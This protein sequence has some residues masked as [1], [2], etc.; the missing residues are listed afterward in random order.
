MCGLNIVFGKREDR[1]NAHA[2]MIDRMGHRGIRSSYWED[3]TV[4]VSHR[5]LPIQGLSEADDQ[6]IRVGDHL[7]WGVGELFNFRSF[8]PG[9]SND[10]RVLLNMWLSKGHEAFA[11]F[12]GFWA[13][14][15]YDL[16]HK[17]GYVYVD[18]LA[19]KPLYAM[20]YNNCVHICSEIF[21]LV[22][23]N[24]EATINRSFYSNVIKWGY[25]THHMTPWEQIRKLPAGMVTS[26]NMLGDF[27]ASDFYNP[28]QFRLG[29]E[30]FINDEIFRTLMR[31][32]VKNRLVS[33]L[34][35]G[36][37][38][39]GGLDS[40][41]ILRLVQEETNDYKVF[42]VDNGA[43]RHYIDL[44]GVPSDKLVKLTLPEE[45][46]EDYGMAIYAHEVPI[47]LGSVLPQYLLAKEIQKHGYHVVLSGDGADE[48]FGGYRRSQTYDSQLSDIL[49]LV[50]YHLPRLDRLM[51]AGTI[52]LRCPFLSWP[53]LN[54]AIEIPYHFR[55][56]KEYLKL[57]FK[58]LI[59]KEILDREKEPLKINAIR[60]NPQQARK[61]TIISYLDE[62]YGNFPV[63]DIKE[64]YA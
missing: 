7:I 61:E 6:P 4:A 52:E 47:D 24:P 10:L 32:S 42:F 25:D 54:Y 8:E 34:P 64:L 38:C 30:F 41:I 13:V 39:S 53:V 44:L 49:E 23:V 19:K 50:H 60:E 12:D 9:A 35:V 21:P 14:L 15:I 33:D 63:P 2:I 40:S 17:I 48:L 28:M 59:P 31:N 5:R 18:H 58:D 3:E 46:Q 37:L 11:L 22:E 26:I 45:P 57:A 62:V 36:V 27:M 1:G 56:K 43:D 51:M 29:R 16:K 55:K 20:N